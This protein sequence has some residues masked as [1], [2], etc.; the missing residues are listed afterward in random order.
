MLRFDFGGIALVSGFT[1]M[2]I[3]AWRQQWKSESIIS[4][5]SW[6]TLGVLSVVTPI[7][8]WLGVQGALLDFI[9]QTILFP[10]W[11]EYQHLRV[12]PEHL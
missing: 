10:I 9:D 11:G 5:I 2:L 4:A 8:I 12:L 1:L 3:V 7:M 6:S